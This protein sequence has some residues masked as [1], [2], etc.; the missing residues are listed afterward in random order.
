MKM[1]EQDTCSG[2]GKTYGSSFGDVSCLCSTC[3]CLGT[4]EVR[5]EKL[6]EENR[7]LKEEVKRLTPPNFLGEGI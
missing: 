5:L 3:S 7:L 1:A 2:C 4:P 6:K